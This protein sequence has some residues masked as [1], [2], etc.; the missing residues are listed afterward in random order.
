MNIKGLDKAKVIT[1]KNEGVSNREVAR[2][3][4]RVAPARQLAIFQLGLFATNID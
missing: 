1:L 2:R 3:A 4:W